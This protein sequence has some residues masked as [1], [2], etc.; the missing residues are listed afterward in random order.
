MAEKVTINKNVFM[1]SA[2]PWTVG[3]LVVMS[4][5][6]LLQQ[7]LRLLQIACR[8]PQWITPK[9]KLAV[10]TACRILPWSRQR[11]ARPG[12]ARLEAN[13]VAA[14][15]AHS[16]ARSPFAGGRRACRYQ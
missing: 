14:M 3:D 5:G 15:V 6:Q 11:C 12:Q 9:P 4:R 7:R 2:N 1:V 8:P 16:V 13:S 10:R